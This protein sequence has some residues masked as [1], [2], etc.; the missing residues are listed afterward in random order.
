MVDS[1]GTECK[2]SVVNKR[3]GEN[4]A[5]S[6]NIGACRPIFLV[7]VWGVRSVNFGIGSFIE[8]TNSRKKNVVA[9]VKLQDASR[10]W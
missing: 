9:I 6:N 1:I 7:F 8:A 2:Q 5:K 3:L 10:R 4:E